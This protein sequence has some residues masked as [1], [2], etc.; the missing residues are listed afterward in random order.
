MT[1]TTFQDPDSR[2]QSLWWSHSSW[3][4]LDYVTDHR[5]FLCFPLI[6]PCCV[7][8]LCRVLLLGDAGSLP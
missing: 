8:L 1:P 4:Y 3:L 6:L 7:M 2:L 5:K